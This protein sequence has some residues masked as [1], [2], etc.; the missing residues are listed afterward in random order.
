VDGINHVKT[1]KLHFDHNSVNMIS[2]AG[3][4]EYIKKGDEVQEEPV[5]FRNHAMDALRYNLYTRRPSS[6]KPYKP[7]QI[8]AA[9]NPDVT[10]LKFRFNQNGR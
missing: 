2:E 1:L 4:Y 10:A 5:D 8:K 3:S 7:D 6:S 9:L